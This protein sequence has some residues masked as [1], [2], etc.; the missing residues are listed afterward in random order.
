MICECT[1]WLWTVRLRMITDHMA[2]TE[3]VRQLEVFTGARRRACGA[4]KTR[5]GS[6]LRL[7]TAAS[8][9]PGLPDGM[10]C[11]RSSCLAGDVN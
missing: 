11:R 1:A 9:Y 2:I 10:A 7:R 8:L 6:L 5:R 4:M 3:P